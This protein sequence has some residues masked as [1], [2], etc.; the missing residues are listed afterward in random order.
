MPTNRQKIKD[1]VIKA[2]ATRKVRI[3]EANAQTFRQM[4]REI[5]GRWAGEGPWLS[6]AGPPLIMHSFAQ[7][8]TAPALGR[9]TP[10]FGRWG[11][12]LTGA[13]N[14]AEI[15]PLSTFRTL[16]SLPSTTTPLFPF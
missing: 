3:M 9:R 5:R 11:L 2:G 13:S 7:V 6:T 16:L 1:E 14:G 12:Q 15:Y 8:L 10:L 4:K